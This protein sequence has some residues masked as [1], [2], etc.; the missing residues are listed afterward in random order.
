MAN[1]QLTTFG[2]FT[3]PPDVSDRIY[4]WSYYTEERKLVIG[5]YEAGDYPL[6]S[7]F[8]QDH[9]IPDD[10][11]C[12]TICTIDAPFITLAGEM[13]QAQRTLLTSE[14]AYAVREAG[15]SFSTQYEALI[16]TIVLQSQ[17]KVIWVPSRGYVFKRKG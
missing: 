15:G 9:G 6:Q 11:L 12:A 1:D 14:A 10:E 17:Y 3:I 8:S 4:V 7:V 2:T 16:G 5:T 13:Y